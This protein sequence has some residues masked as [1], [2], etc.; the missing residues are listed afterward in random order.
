MKTAIY[1]R[2][3]TEEQV[4]EGYSIS[5]QKQ[6]LQS[7]CASQ[8]WHIVGFYVDEGVSAKDMNRPELN[9][10][11]KAIKSGEVECVLVYRLDRLTRSVFDLYK[12]LEIF[13]QHQCKFKS[14]TEVY[15]TT[16]AMGRMFITIVAAL[17]QWERENLAE[18]IKMGQN[19]KA[20]QGKYV[21]RTPH[22]GYDLDKSNWQLVI[23]EDEAKVV[24]RIYEMYQAGD[25]MNKIATTL[26]KEKHF[27]RYGNSW[28]DNTIGKILK[29]KVYVGTNVWG[30]VEVENTHEPIVPI[31]E[32]T[33]V[34]KLIKN[35]ASLHPQNAGSG[36]IFS[37]TLRC[38]SCGSSL[39]GT[40]ANYTNKDQTKVKY[41]YYRCRKHIRA[42]CKNPSRVMESRMEEAF[43]EYISRLDGN[44][45][46]SKMDVMSDPTEQSYVAELN[47]LEEELS[48]LK[49]RKK[50]FQFAWADDAIEY[51]DF[52]ER[53]EELQDQETRI[54]KEMNE[55][56]PPEEEHDLDEEEIKLILNSIRE[57]WNKLDRKEKKALVLSI[58]KQIHWRKE[59]NTKNQRIV[60]EK[61]DFI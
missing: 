26:N 38:S 53:M 19:E 13:D 54:L 32:W 1:I 15:D 37:G 49:N 21:H 36:Y 2:V 45:V 47:H 42:A 43:L 28:S 39:S 11:M 34:Q 33:A 61:L 4:K 35:R 8:D 20:R 7:F 60:I 3:S 29:H 52:K 56:Q 50:K 12:L 16:T 51:E 24:R 57:N 10:M 22:F 23:R 17:A 44:R 41:R 6:K 18:R 58:I 48:K 9:K 25:G 55:L 46:I 31:D 30:E 40:H 14:A 59:G 5:A 27:T